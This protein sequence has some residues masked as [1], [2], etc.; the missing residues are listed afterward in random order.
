MATRIKFGSNLLA[1]PRLQVAPLTLVR[2]TASRHSSH[3]A[4]PPKGPFSAP[5]ARWAL[6][7]LFGAAGVALAAHQLN[8]SSPLNRARAHRDPALTP[9]PR[10]VLEPLRC[11]AE[12]RRSEKLS[13]VVSLDL[14]K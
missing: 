4:G 13:F 5:A 11:E 6:A 9:S 1:Q 12:A 14:M 8:V 10:Q 2:R 3:F 7:G